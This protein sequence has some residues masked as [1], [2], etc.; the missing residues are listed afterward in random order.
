MEAGT[1]GVGRLGP[2]SGGCGQ[3]VGPGSSMA[4]DDTQQ[5]ELRESAAR[6]SKT[7][8][9][10]CSS[11]GHSHHESATHSIRMRGFKRGGCSAAGQEQIKNAPKPS[12]NAVQS[13]PTSSNRL[14]PIGTFCPFRAS[15]P[16][17]ILCADFYQ[18]C[19]RHIGRCC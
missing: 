7:S 15:V 12:D 14:P 6:S 8:F 11:I 3:C 13:V 9:A 1:P 5:A 16:L 2:V 10:A 18:R 17:F 4:K 19:Q